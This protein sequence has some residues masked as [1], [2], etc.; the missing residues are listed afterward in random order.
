MTLD[1]TRNGKY[2]SSGLPGSPDIDQLRVE[3][4]YH[5]EHMLQ[6]KV[7]VVVY[8]HHVCVWR[9]VHLSSGDLY[10][11]AALCAC[12]IFGFLQLGAQVKI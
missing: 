1:I 10:A 7:C 5:S 6:F 8:G 4:R 9:G 3:V 11:K 2:G 12:F